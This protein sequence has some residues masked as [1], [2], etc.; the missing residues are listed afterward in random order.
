MDLLLQQ[1][2]QDASCH[3]AFPQIRDDWTERARAIGTRAGAR[4]IFAPDEK[5]AAA[6]VEIQ[7]DIFA[8]KI[9][10]WMYGQDQREHIPF[11]IHQAAHGDFAPFLREAIAP[12]IPDFIADGM[13]LSRDLRGRRSVH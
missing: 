4:G 11:I 13:Y 6:T 1:C 7:R 10:N 3:K 8:E 2:E 5:S 9:R 12:S